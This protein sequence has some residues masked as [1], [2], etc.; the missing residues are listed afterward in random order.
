MKNS[1]PKFSQVANYYQKY[2]NSCE[3]LKNH[4]EVKFTTLQR[5]LQPTCKTTLLNNTILTYRLK[6][7][8]E[9]VQ[10]THIPKTP[11]T[12]HYFLIKQTKKPNVNMLLSAETTKE[13]MYKIN[14]V[15]KLLKPLKND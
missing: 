1:A 3:K 13:L 10:I 7:T 2:L 8:K 9:N 14:H 6:S 5:L 11:L 4:K 15:Y 12:V